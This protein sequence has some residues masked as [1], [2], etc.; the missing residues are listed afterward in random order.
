MAP[1]QKAGSSFW[2]SLQFIPMEPFRVILLGDKG[3][4][5]PGSVCHPSPRG[6]V[7]FPGEEGAFSGDSCR[8]KP[9]ATGLAAAGGWTPSEGTGW[10]QWPH[11]RAIG[12]MNEIIAC[13]IPEMPG[14]ERV[15]IHR[16]LSHPGSRASAWTWLCLRTLARTRHWKWSSAPAP[17]GTVA[18]PAR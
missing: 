12:R 14:T 5:V 8:C 6:G 1:S 18:R 11:D 10:A 3:V 2:W 4:F 16:V 17:P 15:L 9:F 13:G 7:T